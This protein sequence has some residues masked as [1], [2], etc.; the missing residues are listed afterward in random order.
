M[1]T[2]L[3]KLRE[4]IW[5]DVHFYVCAAY[6]LTAQQSSE[7]DNTLS[8]AKIARVPRAPAI[9]RSGLSLD[10]RS[11]V[12]NDRLNDQFGFSL[13][14]VARCASAPVC[15]RACDIPV[16]QFAAPFRHRQ[17]SEVCV[18]SSRTAFPFCRNRGDFG[19]V[20][21]QSSSV[22]QRF[23]LSDDHEYSSRHTECV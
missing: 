6:I 11:R 13:F 14:R 23:L 8:V 5:R 20:A 1:W 16:Y 2:R 21:R 7:G 3:R 9:S 17:A 22:L 12:T 19:K 4:H 18:P 10:C 15:S